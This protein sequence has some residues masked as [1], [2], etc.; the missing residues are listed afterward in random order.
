[1][2]AIYVRSFRGFAIAMLL[3]TGVITTIATGGGGSDD[4]GNGFVAGPTLNITMA[5]GEDVASALVLAL[6]ISFDLGEIPGEDFPVPIA[7]LPIVKPGSGTPSNLL[8]RLQAG[9][10]MELQSC[11]EGGT[12]DITVTVRDPDTLSIGDRIVAV[13]DSCGGFEDTVLTGTVDL[14]VAAIEGDPLTEMFLL[15][16]DVLFVNVVMSDSENIVTANANFRLTLDS[17]DYPVY[18]MRLAGAELELGS[19]NETIRLTNFDHYVSFDENVTPTDITAGASGRLDSSE[20]NG[21]VDYRTESVIKAWGENDPHDGR[22]L[23]SGANESSMRIII[24]DATHVTLEI[25]ENGDGVI[26]EYIDTTWAALTGQSSSDDGVA[27]INTTTAPIVAR[28]AYNAV[29]GFGSLTVGAGLQFAPDTVFWQIDQL[30]IAGDFDAIVIDCVLGGTATV[31]GSKAVPAT[32]SAG[33]VLIAVFDACGRGDERLDGSLRLTIGSFEG[34]AGDA[35]FLTGTAIETGLQRT[36][37]NCFLG[38]GSLETTVDFR[39]TAAPMIFVNNSASSFLVEAGGRGQQLGDAAVN[40][41]IDMTPFGTVVKRASS[42]SFTSDD[43]SGVM[44]YESI[45]P[46]EFVLDTSVD[47]GPFTGDLLVTASDGS[48]LR[49]VAV[50]EFTVRLDIDLDGDSIVDHDITSTWA[51]LEYPPWTCEASM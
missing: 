9:E 39:F 30:G 31:S 40:T 25:D 23:V 15:G 16:L 11:P 1:M 5:N 50:D 36:L 29:K 24:V 18:E 38:T 35:Y 19:N 33:D 4:G 13:F 21:S 34:K 47:T 20:L 6:G 10:L 3:A 42:G 44:I 7:G 46:D 8:S 2:N 37:D 32:F 17:R 28:E 14:T 12:V 26:D 45:V 22:I 41:Q 51:Q 43:V 27:I 49:L 48:S